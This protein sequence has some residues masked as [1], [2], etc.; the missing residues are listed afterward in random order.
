MNVDIWRQGTENH[1]ADMAIV[2]ELTDDKYVCRSIDYDY[3]KYAK[4]ETV[5]YK[6]DGQSKTVTVKIYQIC[7]VFPPLGKNVREAHFGSVKDDERQSNT[8]DLNDIPR[9]GR[10]ITN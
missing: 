4:D 3:F 9:K 6:V 7:L 2:D 5:T 10:V 8:F 1:Y